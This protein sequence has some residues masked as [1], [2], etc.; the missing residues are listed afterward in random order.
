LFK[1]SLTV[2][3]FLIR[4]VFNKVNYFIALLSNYFAKS[5]RSEKQEVRSERG[6]F[7]SPTFDKNEGHRFR[8]FG[9]NDIVVGRLLLPPWRDRND[10]GV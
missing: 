9:R 5:L 10:R 3:A 4:I 2:S 1:G 6:F 8:L 7:T